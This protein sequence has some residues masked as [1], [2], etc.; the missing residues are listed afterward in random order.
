M[1]FIH[2]GD[3]H[4]GKSVAPQQYGAEF[5]RQRKEELLKTAENMVQFANEN[6][7]DLILCA[8]DLFDSEDVHWDELNRLNK[9][10]SQLKSCRFVTVAGNH[11]PLQ[12]G[13]AYEKIDWVPQVIFAPPGISKISFPELNTTIHTYSWTTKTMSEPKLENWHPQKE[14]ELDILLLHGDA[15]MA[16]SQYLP[17]S[18]SWLHSLPM[19]YIALGHIHRACVLEQHIRYSGSPEPQDISETGDH[20]FW[21]CDLQQGKCTV[22]KIVSAQRVCYKAELELNSQYA[23]WQVR[24]AIYQMAEKKGLKNL[25]D[26]SL[27]GSYSTE[28]PI[29]VE[30]LRQDLLSE[31]VLCRLQNKM[32]PDYDLERLLEE[33]R[34]N[35]IGEF[36]QLFQGKTLDAVEEQA[37]RLGV[38]ALLEE[39]RMQP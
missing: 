5:S 38:E 12:T 35:L 3:W 1:R 25:Y 36:I 15:L 26:I 33:N 24:T 17:L 22:Q 8:G 27:T 31:G 13:G 14:S 20:G 28:K 4:I 10:F 19:D 39:K 37:L 32:R 34:G 11:D 30:Q 7:V 29:D 21:L 2:T 23:P 6:Q 9:I 18:Q 16:Q